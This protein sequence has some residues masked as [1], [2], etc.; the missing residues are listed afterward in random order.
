MNSLLLSINQIVKFGIHPDLKVKNKESVLEKH[1]V[2]IYELYFKID[3]EFDDE[4]YPPF[5]DVPIPDIP[6][7]V[8]SNFRDYGEYKTYT[9]VNDL[10]TV[11]KYVI[12][13]PCSDL[14]CIIFNLLEVKWRMENNS[15]ADG[16]WYFEFTFYRMRVQQKIINL[17][18]Y[19]RR[20]DAEDFMA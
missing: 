14:S 4:Q 16:L 13:D 17:L 1:L 3:Y 15:I 8:Q 6:T 2:K 7:I 12:G 18:K 11:H 10:N 20:N 5:D 9:D 19:L